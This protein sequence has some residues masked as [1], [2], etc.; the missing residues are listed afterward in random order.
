MFL[1]VEGKRRE[2][3][4]QK[5]ET[6]AMWLPKPRICCAL[7]G[8][9]VLQAA[10]AHA[11]WDQRTITLNP[12]WNAVYMAL[13]PEP[14]DPAAVFSG[15]PLDSVWTWNRRKDK[16]QFVQNANKLR[17]TLPNWMVYIPANRPE[18]EL[19]NLHAIF[20][21]RGYLIKVSGTTPVEWVLRGRVENR[22]ITWA[23]DALSLVG[24][25]VD[26]VFPPTFAD[27]FAPS[28]AHSGQPI[29]DLKADGQWTAV[30]NP[31]TERIVSNKAYWVMTKGNSAYEGPLTAEF[32]FGKDVSYGTK[33]DVATLV[34]TNH[35]KVLRNVQL[36]TAA[37]LAPTTTQFPAN[38]GG[39]PLRYKRSGQPILEQTW[40]PMSGVL[41]VA[42]PAQSRTAVKLEVRRS[43]MD[44]SLLP[45]GHTKGEY[46]NVLYVSDDHG[47]L[48]TLGMTADGLTDPGAV[49]KALSKGL[50][51]PGP[52]TGLWVGNIEINAVSQPT[53]DPP[54]QEPVPVPYG[55]EFQYRIILHVDTVGAVRLLSHVTLMKHTA[56]LV[57]IPD[58]ISGIAGATRTVVDEN[59]P[60]YDVLI[61]NDALFSLARA[62][63][64]RPLYEG[65]DFR[66]DKPV[67]KRVVTMAFQDFRDDP[68]NALNGP[69]WIRL[70]GQFPSQL[71]E[72]N[73][74]SVVTT[75]SQGNDLLVLP[76]DD[77]H[78]PFIHQFHPERSEWYG[79]HHCES[80]RSRLCWPLHCWRSPPRCYGPRAL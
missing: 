66:G 4:R 44:S 71:Y 59:Q 30:Q 51:P 8:V 5:M 47:T 7:F 9:A 15:L 34:I 32:S 76:F 33:Q 70:T 19:T 55:H 31:D 39:V 57:E 68:G 62:D 13:Q 46:Q 18:T 25:G 11:Q 41:D 79:H 2:G 21:G 12:G 1:K 20:T 28:T 56:R 45:A 73:A 63:D 64:G 78:N 24:F 48:L 40:E 3:A 6:N 17:P 35:S 23:P 80:V 26:P 36:V 14:N 77:P 27:F 61:T 74:F 29:F 65:I 69:G 53:A 43:E 75:D 67:G 52:R 49:A 22:P 54:I 10:F 50:A 58:E 42:V 37:S 72:D 38:L 60:G 16:I